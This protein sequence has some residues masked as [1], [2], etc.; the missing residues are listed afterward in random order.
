MIRS[1]TIVEN[2][3]EDGKIE[4]N[5]SGDL[6]LEEVARALIVVALHTELPKKPELKKED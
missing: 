2:K 6:P 4:Y 1:F 3:K 5:F